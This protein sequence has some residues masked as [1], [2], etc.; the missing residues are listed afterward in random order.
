M[1]NFIGSMEVNLDD[2]TS[3]FQ[4]VLNEFPSDQTRLAIWVIAE[5]DLSSINFQYIGEKSPFPGS[6]SVLAGTGLLIEL[7]SEKTDQL[8]EVLTIPE[9]LEYEI[10]HIQI[11]CQGTVHFASYDHFSH[12]FFGEAISLAM[13]EDLKTRGI[14][15]SYQLS[16]D[17]TAR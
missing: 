1:A 9:R 4:A 13:L 10:L 8:I 3:L 6:D 12:V 11:E 2:C 16:D 7:K 15:C 5:C 14:V 17:F